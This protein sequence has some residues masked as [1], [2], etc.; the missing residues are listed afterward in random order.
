MKKT[1]KIII[2]LICITF[3]LIF[4]IMGYAGSEMTE[5]QILNINVDGIAKD[6]TITIDNFSSLDITVGN[7]YLRTAK[8]GIF[9]IIQ[10]KTLE[11][12][13]ITLPSEFFEFINLR[14]DEG[15]LSINFSDPENQND[16]EIIYS[17]LLD[18]PIILKSPDLPLNIKNHA[19]DEMQ[20]QGTSSDSIRIQMTN[21]LK[22][23][24]SNL[25]SLTF[26]GS[27]QY[28]GYN[29]DISFQKTSVEKISMENF[30]GP[31]HFESD[32]ISIVKDLILKV[33]DNYTQSFSPGNLCISKFTFIPEGENANITLKENS[34]FSTALNSY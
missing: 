4:G 32:S 9:K 21:T 10:N 17:I 20:I 23:S 34:G 2:S 29:L 12:P 27:Q 22:L 8:Q 14:C 16:D 18:R 25:K 6:S 24:D 11:K 19:F 28:R 30:C 13:E 1:S 33:P 7:I 31:L 5:R 15:N 3:I 26:V